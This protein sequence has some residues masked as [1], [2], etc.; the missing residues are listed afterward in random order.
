MSIANTPAVS[1]P[2]IRDIS[3]PLW[4]PSTFYLLNSVFCLLFKH[5]FHD[6]DLDGLIG[7]HVISNRGA[8]PRRTP[9]HALSRAASPARSVRVAHSRRSLA[10]TRTSFVE[11]VFH[12]VDL[13]RLI[14]LDVIRE[15]ENGFVL[16]PAV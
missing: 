4:L 6:V 1:V 13:D 5:V 15:F 7:L 8:S 3:D 2:V 14:G 10:G 11:H 16:R 12:D 9:L